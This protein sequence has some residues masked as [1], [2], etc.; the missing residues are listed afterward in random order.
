VR[1]SGWDRS[2]GPPITAP[3]FYTVEDEEQKRQFQLGGT[4]LGTAHTEDVLVYQGRRRALQPGRGTHRDGQFIVMES[5]SH[6][7]HRVLVLPASEPEGQFTLV[8]N[9]E[10]DHEYF[11]R[12]RNGLWFIRTKRPRAQIFAW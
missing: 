5:A 1:S 11:D 10:D 6:T 4:G 7:H 12:P 3:S 8:S 2:S 9:R